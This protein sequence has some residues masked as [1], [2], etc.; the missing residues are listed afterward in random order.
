MPDINP[1]EAPGSATE[2]PSTS[3]RR[4]GGDVSWRVARTLFLGALGYGVYFLGALLASVQGSVTS[5]T[6]A[7]WVWA[8]VA[9]FGLAASELFVVKAWSL[10]RSLLRRIGLSCSLVIVSV[11]LA[12]P[13]C[14]MLGIELRR[15][16]EPLFWPRI[17]V[18]LLVFVFFTAVGRR[19]M[20][21]AADPNR[22]AAP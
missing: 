3:I 13:L 4:A 14:L 11:L 7:S 6:N 22:P 20:A 1:Y 19:I 21:G 2:A 12:G 15:M 18:A 5:L 10:D 9:A 17:G 8:S 16:R